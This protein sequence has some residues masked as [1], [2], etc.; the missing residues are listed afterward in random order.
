MRAFVEDYGCATDSSLEF[1]TCIRLSIASV[2]S[3]HRTGKV[4]GA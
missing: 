2:T 4:D 1:G 3:I